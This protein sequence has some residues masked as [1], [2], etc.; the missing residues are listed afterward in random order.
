MLIFRIVCAVVTASGA[1]VGLAVRLE[2]VVRQAVVVPPFAVPPV[3][4]SWP[5]LPASLEFRRPCAHMV[6]R[7]PEV[8][9]G[10]LA[11]LPVGG[12]PA[13][14]LS[15]YLLCVSLMMS[16]NGSHFPVQSASPLTLS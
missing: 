4:A 7:I 8:P 5:L 13:L 11:A 16:L 9:L 2:V 14:T 12:P 3:V 10:P 6:I 1:A 15:I